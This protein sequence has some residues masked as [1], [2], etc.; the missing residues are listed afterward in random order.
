MT[1]KLSFTSLFFFFL[2]LGCAANPIRTVDN[3]IGF[4]SLHFEEGNGVVPKRD[5]V[6]NFINDE[7]IEFD[8]T[9]ANEKLKS[10][11]RITGT[12]HSS[13][14]DLEILEDDGVVYPATEYIFEN[15]C[16][17]SIKIGTDRK[18]AKILEVSCEGRHGE[19]QAFGSNKLLTRK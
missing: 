15:G 11:S 8:I 5:L 4:G 10:V 17:L 9:S 19:G 3:S 16:W 13:Q 1:R 18:I 14:G 2:L 12:A 6:I 7:K